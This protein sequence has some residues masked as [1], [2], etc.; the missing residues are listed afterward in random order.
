M[1]PEGVEARSGGADVGKLLADTARRIA[2]GGRL[3]TAT[4]ERRS[5]L[6]LL[7]G[8]MFARLA[9]RPGAPPATDRD[10]LWRLAERSACPL[11][12]ELEPLELEQLRRDVAGSD[13]LGE[14]PGLGELY[15]LLADVK[16]TRNRQG[17]L[18]VSRARQ[19]R[20]RAGLFFTPGWLAQQMAAWLLPEHEQRPPRAVLDPACGSGRLL[21]SLAQRLL[22]PATDAQRAAACRQLVQSTLRGVEVDPLAAAICRTRFWLEADPLQGP[23]AGLERLVTVADAI[24]GSL[25]GRQEGCLDWSSVFGGQLDDGG[26]G[27]IVTNPPFEVLRGYARRRGL[28]EYAERIRRSGYQLALQ[29]NLNT[30]RLF[31]E[32]CLQLLRPGGRLA[33]VLPAGFTTDRSAGKLRRRLLESGWL[34]RLNAYPE[35]ERV[36]AGVGQAVVW[37]GVVKEECRQALEVHWG[38]QQA[39]LIE[40]SWIEVLDEKELCIPLASPEALALAAR[41]RRASTGSFEQ[42]ALGRVGEVDQTFFRPFMRSRPGGELL[43]RGEHMA[44]YRVDLGTGKSKERWLDARG[45]ARKKGN[46]PWREH[47]AGSR[48]AQTGIVNME[49]G[50]RLVAARVPAGTYLGNSVNYWLPRG[51]DDWPQEVAS[52]YLLGLLN[53]TPYEWRFRLTSSNN[54]INIYEIKAL[55]WPSLTSEFPPEM[56]AGFLERA[57]ELLAGGN[58]SVLGAIRQITA[59]WG[60][61][62]RGDRA[63]A[64]LIGRAALLREQQQDRQR[65]RWLDAAIDHLVNW[66]LGLDEPDLDLM[67]RR[68]PARA[69]EEKR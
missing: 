18:K 48:I 5:K 56:L 27:I 53:S 58:Y 24:C 60:A 42:V 23:V 67:Y 10:G 51:L 35:S 65:C 63:V 3:Q 22:P 11:L 12:A 39:L 25:D 49:A 69:W 7:L 13:D 20:R 40:H 26:F 41:L 54:N 45:F 6:A 59:G 38:K 8:A 46:G 29:G 43:V 62:D 34:R 68:L 37:L 32:R 47:L 66:H 9:G 57:T 15:Q 31:L 50:R 14:S 44:P 4:L 28:E 19:G 61:P 17:T 1:V 33:I 36:F 21:W 30:W 64:M 2:S 55:P 52:G 16:L